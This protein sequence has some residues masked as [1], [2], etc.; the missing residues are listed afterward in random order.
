VPTARTL[1]ATARPYLDAALQAE[2]RRFFAF[3]DAP[4]PLPP[5]RTV[6]ERATP[7]GAIAL[8]ELDTEYAPWHAS[9]S[10]P[11]C[12][13]NA[14]LSFAHW[15]HRPGR[16]RAVVIALHGFTMGRRWIDARVFMAARWF[17]LGYDVV[18]PLL[19]FH[20]E[21]SPRWAR[22]SGEAFGSWDVGRLNEAVRQAVHD[23]DLVRRI[24]AA[25]VD[26][27]AGLLGLSLGGYVT[28]LL[29]GLRDDLAFAIPVAAPATLAFLPQ[30]LFRLGRRRSAP[31]PVR[32]EILERAY[33]VHSPFS[34][35][36][37]IP[38]RHTFV[39]GGL[40]DCLVPP[41][42]V[43]ALWRHWGEP[44]LAWFSG[45]HATP[46]GRTDVLTRLDAHLRSVL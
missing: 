7:G 12:A 10:W 11:A 14:R 27:P 34:F 19:P 42:Q 31:L 33:R 4:S 15:M 36:L 35:P 45:G 8:R 28:A 44:D 2:P 30:T 22:Y 39:V 20:G 1:E 43:T 41:E 6:D 16:P 5:V 46:F 9:E 25:T 24:V 23:V 32:P 38:R 40:G 21:R 3:L 29:A 37:A 17:T 26:A 13:E 18:L